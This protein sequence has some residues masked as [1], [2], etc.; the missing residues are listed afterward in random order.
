[1]EM[2]RVKSRGPDPCRDHRIMGWALFLQKELDSPQ[3]LPLTNYLDLDKL[4]TSL[5][6]FSYQ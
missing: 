5:S 2:L 4:C 1:M 3:C 6:L